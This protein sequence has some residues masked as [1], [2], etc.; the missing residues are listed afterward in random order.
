MAA[1][2]VRAW[3]NFIDGE[4]VASSGDDRTEVLDP[5]TGAVLATVARSTAEDVDRGVDAAA[6]AYESRWKRSTPRERALLLRA[7]AAAVDA[8]AEELAELETR[9]V[10]K[11]IRETRELD[12]PGT[13]ACFDYYSGWTDKLYGETIP[14]SSMPLLNYTVREPLGVVGAIVP[15]N[16]PLSIGSWKVA[17]ALAAGNTVVL[18]PAGVTPLSM[19]RL[20]ELAREVGFPP[21]V[22][23]VV[24]G[25]AAVGEALVR[26]RRVAKI[27]FTGSTAVGSRIMAR[28]ADTMKTLTLECGGKSAN[29]VF[30]DADLD[31]AIEAT[32][33]GIFLNQGEVCAAGSRLLVQEDIRAEFVDRLVRR[34]E[35]LRVGDPLDPGTQIGALI[36]RSHLDSVHGRVWAGIAEGAEL[37]TGGAPVAVPGLMD[38]FYRPTIL[39]G[40]D[41][42]S[43]LAREEVF[44]PVLAVIP[45]ETADQAVCLAN[46]NMYGLS[47]NIHTNN[48]RVAHTVAASLEAG[49]IFVNLPAIPFAEAPFGGYKMTGIGKDLGRD[50]IE[51]FTIKKSIVVGLA[52]PGQHLRWYD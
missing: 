26:H 5:A 51:A 35:Q 2:I 43:T 10:G 30:A 19:L 20:A 16:G 15:W 52:E 17:P 18:K 47:A 48:L 45:F 49:S 11:P 39:D 4:F 13:A 46:D 14:N 41:N 8:H 50:G 22:F 40:V 7:L 34:A 23:N 27:S 36:S 29:I 32:L 38:T 24:T 21:G 28:A 12:I 6:V 31:E 9:N 42:G 33:F 1:A 3:G 25:P 44:G 37:V